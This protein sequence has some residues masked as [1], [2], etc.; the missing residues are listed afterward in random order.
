[1]FAT[2]GMGRGKFSAT[3]AAAGLGIGILLSG[4]PVA[5]IPYGYSQSTYLVEVEKNRYFYVADNE[6][7]VNFLTETEVNNLPV[8]FATTGIANISIGGEANTKLENLFGNL[9]I[10][11]GMKLDEISRERFLKYMENFDYEG[12][13]VA[14]ILQ[15]PELLKEIKDK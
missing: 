7:Y 1:M 14:S 11:Q 5:H 3:L 9:D 4:T 13:K 8:K 10:V 2:R 15:N 6:I 12:E